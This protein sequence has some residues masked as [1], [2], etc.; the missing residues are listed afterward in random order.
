MVALLSF[1]ALL[2]P[3]LLVRTCPVSIGLTTKG[4]VYSQAQRAQYGVLVRSDVTRFVVKYANA[5]RWEPSTAVSISQGTSLLQRDLPPA[6]PQSGSSSTSEDCLYIVVY[7]PNSIYPGSDA[8]T[9]VWIHGGSFTSGSASDPSIYGANLAAATKSIV[10]NVQYRLGALGFMAPNGDTNL[11]V[12]DV[13]NA[14]T[15]LKTGVPKIGGS[16]SKITIAGQSSGAT[17]VRA[18][19]AIPSASSLFRSAILQ[20]DPMDYGFLSTGTQQTMQ[21]FFNKQ[22]SC[23]PSDDSCASSLSVDEIIKASGTLYSQAMSLDPATGQ[24][25]PIRPVHDGHLITHKLTT[26]SSFPQVSKPILVTTVAN[27]AGPTIY[28]WF[29]SPISEHD[30]QQ[31]VYLTLGSSRADT[32]LASG[33]YTVQAQGGVVDARPGL[34]KIATDYL[35]KCSSWTFS[36]TWAS[37]GGPA[38]VGM[39]VLGATYPTNGGI[40]F[41]NGSVCHQDDIPIVFG[42]ASNPNARQTQLINE[43]Q[44]RYKAFLNTDNPN[45]S[46]LTQWNTATSSSTNAILLGGSGPAPIDACTPSFWGSAVLYDYQVYGL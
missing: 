20:S 2:L 31:T 36:R 23:N 35:W 3:A 25:E 8:S 6:C 46:G 1:V 27:E 34:E 29:S 45:V 17:M 41:C 43:M 40:P 24:G 33:R 44:A 11:A 7:V 30:F 39:Y 42:T 28:G 12:K 4:R 21:N 9:L 37:K 13:I 19:L 22:F 5:R 10:A 14:L 32:V 38:Y 26:T 18:L 16:A 15:V